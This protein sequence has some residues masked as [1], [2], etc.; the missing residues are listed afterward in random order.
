MGGRVRERL[1]PAGRLAAFC[2]VAASLVATSTPGPAT[3]PARFEAATSCGPSGTIALFPDDCSHGCGRC[4]DGVTVEG[5]PEAG[6]PSVG[7]LAPP[8]EGEEAVPTTDYLARGRFILSGVLTLPGSDPAV[9]VDRTCTVTEESAGV[10]A[11]TCRGD[12]PELAACSGTL[13]L[14]P[15]EAP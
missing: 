11:I 12:P 7:A 9:T 8:R 1:R 5:G 6:L 14:L 15:E 10:L 4:G 2:A 3:R 13:T